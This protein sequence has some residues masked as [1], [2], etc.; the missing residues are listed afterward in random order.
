V[1]VGQSEVK[2]QAIILPVKIE[3]GSREGKLT[4]EIKG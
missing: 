2:N 4:C 3:R 1:F